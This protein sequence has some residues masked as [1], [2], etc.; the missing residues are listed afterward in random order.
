LNHLTGV[1]GVADHSDDHA[2]EAPLEALDQVTRSIT[3]AGPHSVD[4]LRI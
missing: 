4:K 3:V 1:V 2:E